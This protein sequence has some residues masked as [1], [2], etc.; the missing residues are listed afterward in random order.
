MS[1]GRLPRRPL[2]EKLHKN[3]LFRLGGVST[4]Q[5]SPDSG[6]FPQKPY[7]VHIESLTRRD[8]PEIIKASLRKNHSAAANENASAV[9]REPLLENLAGWGLPMGPPPGK[10][11]LE[12]CPG[13]AS[14]RA[15][16]W[17]SFPRTS[18]FALVESLPGS[19]P[20]SL[21]CFLKAL[22]KSLPRCLLRAS[23]ENTIPK[24]IP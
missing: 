5:Q 14:P 11:L 18:C 23:R 3:L 10:E 12:R 7:Q 17:K 20:E 6:L 2:A 15:L 13:A 9:L 1:S 4:R 19:I 8:S 16:L 21:D 22:P 24:N